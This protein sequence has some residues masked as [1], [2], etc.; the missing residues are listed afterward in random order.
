MEI[1]GYLAGAGIIALTA[2]FIFEDENDNWW[3]E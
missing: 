3:E 2:Y 1:F